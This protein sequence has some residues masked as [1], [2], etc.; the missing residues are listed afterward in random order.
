VQITPGKTEN[1]SKVRAQC[2][3]TIAFIARYNPS[4]P[5]KKAKTSR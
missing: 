5:L 3:W 1:H 4:L 2:G